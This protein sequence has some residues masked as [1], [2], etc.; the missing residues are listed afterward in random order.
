MLFAHKDRV[1]SAEIVQNVEGR[2]KSQK[3]KKTF[4]KVLTNADS[5]GMICRL[6]RRTAPQG[7]EDQREDLEN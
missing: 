2:K 3:S 5:G 4:K 6:S 7:T 1:L